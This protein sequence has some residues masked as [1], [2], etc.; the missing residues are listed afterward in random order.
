MKTTV[1][2]FWI[3]L[4]LTLVYSFGIKAANFS[5]ALGETISTACEVT[6]SLSS[7]SSTSDNLGTK[8]SALSDTK[9]SWAQDVELG[10]KPISET[11]SYNQQ[12]LRRALEDESFLKNILLMLS[13][14]ENLL[15]QGRTKLYY[16]DKDPYYAVAG[17]DY[18]IFTLRRI[19]I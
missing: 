17:C 4:L 11:Y 13:D 1:K 12:R 6:A 18:Y 19:L 14:H 9:Y 7:C 16:S 2:T 15:V 3:C 10:N 8:E 5:R